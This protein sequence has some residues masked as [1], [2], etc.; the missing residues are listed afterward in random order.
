LWRRTPI[1]EQCVPE[2]PDVL[3]QGG[4]EVWAGSVH[5]EGEKGMRAKGRAG[6]HISVVGGTLQSR[7]YMRM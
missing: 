2:V 1:R 6:M 3:C 7:T 4:A 5:V